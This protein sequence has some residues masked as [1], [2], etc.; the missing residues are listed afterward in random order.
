MCVQQYIIRTAAQLQA[1]A[2][3][4][5]CAPFLSDIALLIS[6]LSRHVLEC[7]D[8]KLISATIVLHDAIAHVQYGCSSGWAAQDFGCFAEHGKSNPLM[9]IAPVK[10]QTEKLLLA[11]L[12]QQQAIF[13]AVPLDPRSCPCPSVTLC[14]YCR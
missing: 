5:D 10:L 13:E 12:M 3:T 1:D 8:F 4:V 6:I 7:N 11:L 9:A 2:D 14:T